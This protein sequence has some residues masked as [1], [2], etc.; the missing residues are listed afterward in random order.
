MGQGLA[1][2]FFAQRLRSNTYWQWPSEFFISHQH[3]F[4]GGAAG[5]RILYLAQKPAARLKLPPTFYKTPK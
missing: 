5:L 4:F 1:R 3:L 2:C